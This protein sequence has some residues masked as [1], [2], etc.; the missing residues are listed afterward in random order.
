MNPEE[1][2]MELNQEECKALLECIEAAMRQGVNGIGG[3]NALLELADKL[4]RHAKS[5]QDNQGDPVVSS[6]QEAQLH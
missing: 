5:L 6:S 4:V 1:T 3:A 2:Q